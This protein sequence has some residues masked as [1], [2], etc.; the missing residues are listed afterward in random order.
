MAVASEPAPT[1]G[2]RTRGRLLE[3]GSAVFAERGFHAARVD[4]VV[5]TGRTIRA[6]MDALMDFGRPKA[7]QVVGLVDRGHR[8]LPIKLDYVGKNLP[9]HPED[10]VRLRTPEGGAAD[11]LEVVVLSR[12]GA[13]AADG[14][15]GS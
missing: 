3:A 4:D 13:D 8:E 11:H 12:G 14:E 9:T 5:K 15:G 10:E 2:E 1:R 7:V 6:A